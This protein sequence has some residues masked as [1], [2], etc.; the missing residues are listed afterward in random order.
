M[1]TELKNNA[2]IKY[3]IK[4]MMKHICMPVHQEYFG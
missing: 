3:I 1:S 2:T 4:N